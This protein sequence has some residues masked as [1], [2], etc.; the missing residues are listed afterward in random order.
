[1]PTLKQDEPASRNKGKQNH[2][3]LEQTLRHSVDEMA[4]EVDSQQ[5]H[6]NKLEIEQEAL[7]VNEA[8]PSEKWCLEDIDQ[9]E[10]AR[11][12]PNELKFLKA[13]GEQV[14]LE[15]IKKMVILV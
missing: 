7:S 6:G 3:P 13:T 2:E 5:D 8:H 9:K 14:E 12:H 1:M 10:K 4:P 15:D 11:S